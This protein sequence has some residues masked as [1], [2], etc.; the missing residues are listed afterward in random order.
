M[1]R[2]ANIQGVDILE[3]DDRKCFGISLARIDCDGPNGNPD[4][5]PF[6][7]P[8]TT[9]QHEGHSLDSYKVPG[10]VL[11]PAAIKG[12]VGIV[13]GCAAR[14]TNLKNGKSTDAVVYERGPMTKFGEMSVECAKRIG[15]N[16]NPNTGGTSDKDQIYYEW[17]PGHAATVD[18]I[19][20][21][22]QP[23]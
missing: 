3:A 5:D 1:R 19:K 7:Q 22:L 4:N 6:W 23:S 9:L 2:I 21:K 20:Y 16:G 12:V 13:M 10:I 11:P 8:G 15:L 14:V 18:G 17:W